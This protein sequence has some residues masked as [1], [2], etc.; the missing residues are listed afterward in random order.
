MRIQK[1][2]WRAGGA[3]AALAV[4]SLAGTPA[5]AQLL[6][7]LLG[8]SAPAQPVKP[9]YGNLKPFYGN[10]K[11]FWGNLKPFWG[12]TTAFYGDFSTFWGVSNP[13]V[14]AGAPEYAKVGD[15]WTAAGT[16]WDS[17][18]RNWDA[19]PGNY[20]ATAG[21][22]KAMVKDARGFWGASVQAKTGKSFEAGFSN[23]IL[24][25]YGINL[26]DPK[27]LSELDQTERAMFFLEW[28]DGLMTFA[29]TDHVDHWMKTVN[30]SP[31]LTRPYGLGSPT[32]IGILDQTLSSAEFGPGKLV[33]FNGTSTFSDGHGAGVASLLIGAHDGKG[34]MGM[35]PESK[36]YAYNPFDSTGTASWDD[37]TEGVRTLKASGASVV[38]MSL[39]VPGMTF[40][41]GWNNVFANLQTTLILKNT[42]FVVAAGNEGAT[43]TANVNW[44]PINPA[45]IVVGSVDVEGNISNF[46]NRPGE[47]CLSTLGL[48]CLPGQ[49]LKDRFIV[50]PGE[51]LLVSDGQGGLTRQ[52][53]TSFAAPIVTGVIAL[54]LEANPNLNWRD[55]KE[56]LIRAA[57]QNDQDALRLHWLECIRTRNASMSDV[58]L[59]TKVM[60]IV[61]LATRSLWQG[62][63]FT[64][65]PVRRSV[66]KA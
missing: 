50:A 20:S 27:S 19:T 8:E 62:G 31:V 66:R 32:A 17:I 65:D 38:N 7:G 25:R 36:V 41:P 6:D 33:Q 47:A 55:V 51:L 16:T 12:D 13:V 11:P 64:Y 15:Y 24:A 44:L 39:G 59:G 30:W 9:M 46:S 49:R 18:F 10:L 61:D 26:S 53:G 5:S 22:L 4:A 43:Q 23:A 58:D 54:M 35:V 56:I 63:A 29:G 45:V 3:A 42:V 52:I 28:Y 60:V 14:G 37:V 1:S 57:R 40:D 2:L 21:A 34:V 48:L